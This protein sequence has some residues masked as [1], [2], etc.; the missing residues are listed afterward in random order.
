MAVPAPKRSDARGAVAEALERRRPDLVRMLARRLPADVD[1]GDVYQRAA[2][3]ALERC[4]EVRDVSR[5]DAWLR[6]VIV[7]TAADVL[8]G[9]GRRE[10][11]VAEVPEP[12]ASVEGATCSCSLALLSQLAPSY[13]EALRLA[14]VEGAT[15]GEVAARLG[16]TKGNAA[17]R[18][19][20]ARHALRERLRE[21]CGTG[22]VRECLTCVCDE[23]G[24]C[25]ASEPK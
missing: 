6:R 7:T 20:R 11:P 21:H 19:H 9:P 22:S 3:R 17:V 5:V 14:D 4:E 1:A 13:A 18:L 8:R 23:R 12:N 24:C 2:V 10:Q 15:L 25:I 16:L